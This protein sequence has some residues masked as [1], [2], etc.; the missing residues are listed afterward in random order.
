[1]I[2]IIKNY[3]NYGYSKSNKWKKFDFEIMDYFNTN[4]NSIIYNL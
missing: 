4:K 2:K 3:F 1:M